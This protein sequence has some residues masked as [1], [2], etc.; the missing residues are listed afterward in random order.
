M[1]R[2]RCMRSAATALLVNVANLGAGVAAAHIA[3]YS[4]PVGI[5]LVDVTESGHQVPKFLWRRLGDANGK[6]L[7]IYDA[8]QSGRSSCYDACTLEFPP[9]LAT[10]HA[11][12][13][14]DF[15]IITRDDHLKQWAYQGKPLYRYNGEDPSGEPNGATGVGGGVFGTAA[16]PA[17]YDPASAL[18]SPKRGWRRAAYAP[19][20]SMQ[21]PPSVQLEGLAIASGFGL[22][23][24]ATH[25]TIY[26]APVSHQLS[27]DW[28]PI[29]A[30]A[31]ALPVGQFS[32]I[33]R[34]DD[35][36]RQW[37]YRGEALYSYAGDY[38]PSEV[39]GI[40]SGDKSVQ[41]ALAYRNFM[42]SGIEIRHF[43]LR[44]PLMTTSR[45]QSLYTLA[46]FFAL[47]GGRETRN[48]YDVSYN[49]AKAQGTQGCQDECTRTW[50]PVV[51]PTK[52][53]AQGFWEIVVRADGTRQ[54]AFRGSPLYSFVGD[55]QPGDI[56]GNNRHVIVY[57][58]PDG[59]AVYVDAGAALPHV[60][61]HGLP[62]QS[63]AC[64]MYLAGGI[65]TCEIG[66]LM[67]GAQVPRRQLVRFAI[68]RRVYTQS[69]VD[70]VGAVATEVAAVRDRLPAMRIVEGADVALRH[71]TATLAPE[72]PFPFS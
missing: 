65:R 52:A 1:N 60:G 24:A 26:A 49:D 20:I 41:A 34:R 38:A 61:A 46:R 47:Y 14:G 3:P 33:T 55:Q 31:L 69:H 6:A 51:A 16:D 57:G 67:F 28:H 42:P 36:T 39:T 25:M 10:A 12:S 22:V 19:E 71:F 5:T 11:S 32:I 27:G 7:Y 29:R 56:T 45:G 23:D 62:G 70:Y 30:S 43:P 54:W 53:Q 2:F 44:G 72:S 40:F 4:T 66:E 18:F 63:L 37:T 15:S 50:Q 58:G 68:P 48:G 21:M 35:H 17:R 64:A 9:F 8:D 59:Q 13:S